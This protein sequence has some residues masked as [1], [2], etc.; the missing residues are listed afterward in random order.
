MI[1]DKVLNEKELYEAYHLLI[2]GS[3]VAV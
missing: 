2:F 1:Y 3:K